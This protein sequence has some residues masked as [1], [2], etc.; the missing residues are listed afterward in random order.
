MNDLGL[1]WKNRV[2]RETVTTYIFHLGHTCAV[3]EVYTVE[4]GCQP[5]ITVFD[6]VIMV[7]GIIITD[8]RPSWYCCRRA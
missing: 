6:Q 4:S 5:M 7:N 3:D 8:S 1:G 2:G